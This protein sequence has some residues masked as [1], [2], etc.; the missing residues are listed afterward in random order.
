MHM[1]N[2]TELD[3]CKELNKTQSQWLKYVNEA[4]EEWRDSD[5][6]INEYFD[7]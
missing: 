6:E 7:K 1:Q 5:K 3:E 2:E 4:Y